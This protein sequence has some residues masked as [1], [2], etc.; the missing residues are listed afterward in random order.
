M[1]KEDLYQEFCYLDDYAISI[2]Y[3]NDLYI[4]IY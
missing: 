1:I 4:V 3:Q 2:E